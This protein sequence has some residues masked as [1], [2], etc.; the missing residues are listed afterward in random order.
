MT[1]RHRAPGGRVTYDG[2]YPRTHTIS[3]IGQTKIVYR[4]LQF[5]QTLCSK[6]HAYRSTF[7]SILCE[8]QPSTFGTLSEKVTNALNT[9]KN[10]L[11]SPAVL[12]LPNSTGHI[13]IDNDNCDVELG[14][15]L[16]KQKP[17]EATKL[18]GCWSRSFTDTY[19]TTKRKYL[20]IVWLI[21]FLQP[22]QKGTRLIIRIDHDTLKRILNLTYSTGRVACWRLRLSEFEFNVV[23][24]AGTQQRR[25]RSPDSAHLMKT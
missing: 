23:H 13:T 2:C 19:D 17:D 7:E 8:D 24:R 4:L 9:L 21:F 6:P 16:L 15:V 3:E 11:L 20:A 1:H 5:I 14:W 12:T 18:I 22:Y 25:M 10:A